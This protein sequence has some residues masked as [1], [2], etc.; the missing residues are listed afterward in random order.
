M[1]MKEHETIALLQRLILKLAPCYYLIG[2]TA[3]SGFSNIP[4]F[5]TAL[6]V[7]HQVKDITR[8]P[9]SLKCMLW[10]VRDDFYEF[11][12]RETFK[13]DNGSRSV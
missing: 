9:R 10:S 4:A 2:L 8:Y 12:R 7:H 5:R 11:C 3:A 6:F 13:V 1:K